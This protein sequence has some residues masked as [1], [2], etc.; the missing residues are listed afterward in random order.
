MRSVYCAV[1]TGSL[2]KTVYALSFNGLRP[3]VI[4]VS[5]VLKQLYGVFPCGM[6]VNDIVNEQL[7]DRESCIY[8]HHFKS[9]SAC[10]MD[11]AFVL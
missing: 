9:I 4:S 11:M 7:Q 3:L 10:F 5:D 1:Q 8:V 6:L 2:N